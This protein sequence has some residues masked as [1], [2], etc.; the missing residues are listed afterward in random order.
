MATGVFKFGAAMCHALKSPWHY[1]KT[2]KQ[3][4][5]IPSKDEPCS[6]LACFLM[7]YKENNMSENTER[8]ILIIKA[9]FDE[10]S[11]SSKYHTY[12]SAVCVY[13]GVHVTMQFKTTC[14]SVWSACIYLSILLVCPWPDCGMCA[15]FTPL[16]ITG[17]GNLGR[18][19]SADADRAARKAWTLLSILRYGVFRS[20]GFFD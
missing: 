6:P 20:G 4:Y 12:I 3:T 2:K 7:N 17:S 8:I 15:H 11:L 16:C 19:S 5:R 13:V 18:V 10:M 1:D 14:L 9:T